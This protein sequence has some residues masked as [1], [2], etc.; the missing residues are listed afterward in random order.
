MV[1]LQRERHATITTNTIQ[2]YSK[3]NNDKKFIASR[4]WVNK[5][6]DRRQLKVVREK[7]LNN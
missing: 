2:I 7:L 1:L 4:G 5:L 6:K 3:H